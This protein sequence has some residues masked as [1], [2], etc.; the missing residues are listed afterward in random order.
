M[1]P[2]LRKKNRKL[3]DE[4]KTKPCLVC[5]DPNTDPCHIKSVGAGG[6]DEESNVLPMC[7]KHHSESH[8]LGWHKFATT[9]F[10]MLKILD[11]Y[12]W[13]FVEEFGVTKL[14]KKK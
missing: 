5:G 10:H 8:S 7:R 1:K 2:F 9:H 14:R 13:E 6:S 3:L 11:D 4:V 12:G